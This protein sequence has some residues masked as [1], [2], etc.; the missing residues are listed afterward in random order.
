[1]SRRRQGRQGHQEGQALVE[2]ALTLSLFSLFVMVV[3]Q[4]GLI[5]VSYYSETRMARETA[6]WLAV[7]SRLTDDSELA[8]HVNTTMLPGL[9][10]G[11]PSV[12]AGTALVDAVATV[13][14]MRV[15]Y[16]PCEPNGTIC[17]HNTRAPGATLYVEMTYD[18]AGSHLL[19]L[20]TG[21]RIGSLS[22]KIPTALP[23]YRVSVMVE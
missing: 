10:N 19:F 3:I 15:T 13:G 23:P 1:M 16:T 14:Q 11:T 4:F 21:F 5:F 12:T 22:V 20:P 7:N 17:T 2:F 18:I 6:R 9:V 8:D